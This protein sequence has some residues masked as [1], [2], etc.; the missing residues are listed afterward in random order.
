MKIK[1][2][3]TEYGIAFAVI[4]GCLVIAC[5]VWLPWLTSGLPTTIETGF[6]DELV[7][8]LNEKYELSIPDSA[9][10]L[11]G[12]Y[13]NAMQD[14]A[15][16]IAFTVPKED[17]KGMFSEK[18]SEDLYSGWDIS[19]YKDYIDFE[20]QGVRRFSG[21]MFTS[22]KYSAPDENGVISCGASFRHPGDVIR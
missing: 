9:V 13:D 4:G 10:F 5:I 15:V 14:D 1:K 18:W 20:I 8:M 12:Y 17:F 6:S 7:G 16:H 3:I 11:G 21:E 22:L 2:L 19:A